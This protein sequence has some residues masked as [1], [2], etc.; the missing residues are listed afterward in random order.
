[1]KRGLILL[2]AF[3][4]ALFIT[5]CGS[6]QKTPAKSLSASSSISTSNSKKDSA[7]NNNA[8]LGEELTVGSWKI[9]AS[10]LEFKKAIDSGDGYTQFNPDS[11]ENQFAVI[12]L[13][14]TNSGKTAADFIP[15]IS[16]DGDIVASL[17]Y[18]SD[19]KY[20]PT[21]LIGLDSNMTDSTMNPLSSKEGV[22]AFEVPPAVTSG[23]GSLQLNFTCGNAT[24]DITLK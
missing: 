5:A 19:Y 2:T 8:K 24:G 18:A 1:M 11:S 22:V 10:S 13:K 4:M 17:R 7:K 23:K 21:A 9:T 6:E 15:S 20:V 16:Q 3:A 12:H 14:A